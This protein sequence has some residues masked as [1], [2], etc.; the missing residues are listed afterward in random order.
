MRTYRATYSGAF[1]GQERWAVERADDGGRVLAAQVAYDDTEPGSQITDMLEQVDARSGV[2]TLDVRKESLMGLTLATTSSPR[3][4]RDGNR[5][6]KLRLG[7]EFST[8]SRPP[9]VIHS[10]T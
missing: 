2:R 7:W 4:F 8:T 5:A 6:R 1:A 10:P 9:R 3:H